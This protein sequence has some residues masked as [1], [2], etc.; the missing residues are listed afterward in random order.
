MA[1]LEFKL[2]P[3]LDSSSPTDTTWK[4]IRWTEVKN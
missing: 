1:L 3:T 2:A 4:V